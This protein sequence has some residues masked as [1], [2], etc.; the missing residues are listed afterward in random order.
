MASTSMT[1]LRRLRNMVIWMG[2]GSI[3][4]LSALVL[5]AETALGA[6]KI[7]FTYG[8]FGQSLTVK[9]L[10]TFAET[11]KAT[12]KLKF[13]LNAADQDPNVVRRFL[14]QD[15]KIS[16]RLADR[17][18][19]LL[20]GEYALFQAGQIFR[21][22]GRV[23][24]IQA[25]RSGVIQSLSDDGQISLLEFLEKYPLAEMTIDGVKLVR[26]AGQIDRLVSR[27]APSVESGAAIA[28]GLLESLVCDCD[29]TSVPPNPIP[30]QTPDPD[31]APPD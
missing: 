22:P 5:Q 16:L 12:S 8:P 6:T 1:G 10:K 26:T 19:Y 23:A 4:T 18:L 15:V 31:A 17:L 14:A 28:T 25:L 9:E 30:E 7:K 21:T 20:P 27:F 13:F 29:S 3:C 11:G 24:N 2:L